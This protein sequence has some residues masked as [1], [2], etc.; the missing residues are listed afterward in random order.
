MHD[1]RL[2]LNELA[3]KNRL[4]KSNTTDIRGHAIVAAPP[5]SANIVVLV[6][7]FLHG[8]A[9][10]LSAKVDVGWLYML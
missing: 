2:H 9:V 3:D 7:P 4:V 10:H 1:C 8:A 5:D 6:D